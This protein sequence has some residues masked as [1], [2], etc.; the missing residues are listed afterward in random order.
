M[1]AETPGATGAGI[2]LSEA[3]L[4]PRMGVYREADSGDFLFLS[5]EDGT[6]VADIAL[7]MVFERMKD[8]ALDGTKPASQFAG[9]AFRGPLALHATWSTH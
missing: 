8:L 2:A 1:T 9:W 6:L 7:P 4:S 5:V 3:E